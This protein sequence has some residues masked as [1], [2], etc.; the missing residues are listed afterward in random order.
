MQ[1]GDL[2][3]GFLADIQKGSDDLPQ[4]TILAKQLFGPAKEGITTRFA[5]DQS[6]VL[7]QTTD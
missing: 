7:E 1:S 4:K 3:A 5:D 2:S 6:L